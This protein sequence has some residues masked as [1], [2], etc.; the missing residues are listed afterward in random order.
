MHVHAYKYKQY[1]SCAT[2]CYIYVTCTFFYCNTLGLNYKLRITYTLGKV[3][4][5]TVYVSTVV[6]KYAPITRVRLD[7]YTCITRCTVMY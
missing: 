7:N 2:Q 4:T 1:M 5:Y 6:C 3:Y